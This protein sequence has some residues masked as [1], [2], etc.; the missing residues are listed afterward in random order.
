VQNNFWD[1]LTEAFEEA[2]GATVNMEYSGLGSSIEERLTQLIQAGDPPEVRPVTGISRTSLY[3]NQGIT[4]PVTDVIE[5]IEEMYDE[6]MPERRRHIVDG[7]DYMVPIAQ[8]I[9]INW[10]RPDR[11]GDMTER[12]TWDDFLSWARDADDPSG[13]RG[14]YVPVGGGFCPD[15]DILSWAYSN[16]TKMA[17][18]DENGEVQIVMGEGEHR[19][20]WI[21]VME[22]LNELYEYSAPAT[23]SSCS[24]LVQV[25]P[26]EIAYSVRY[27]GSRQKIQ[28]IQQEK[29]FAESLSNSIQPKAPDGSHTAW[30]TVEGMTTYQG[31]NVEAAKTFMRFAFQLEHQVNFF[32]STPGLA[33]HAP[34][35]WE[36]IRGSDPY[37]DHINNDLPDAWKDEDKETVLNTSREATMSIPGETEPPNPYAGALLSS[38]HVTDLTYDV[39]VNDRDPAEAVDDWAQELQNVLD[40]AKGG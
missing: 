24:T 22:Y 5:D 19:E 18:R 14:T 23:D 11:G 32:S 27:G 34:S 31:A 16:D 9:K 8:A 6:E 2:T 33:L 28:A 29:E 40:Q 3:T 35:P 1:P 26:G 38:N 30:Q 17:G 13:T 20:R 21:E 12:P 7:E 37:Q 15:T 25:I 39:L 4:E 36:G 10:F